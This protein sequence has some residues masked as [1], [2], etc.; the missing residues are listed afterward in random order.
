MLFT[1]LKQE[2][3]IKKDPKIIHKCWKKKKKGRET[4]SC[5]GYDRGTSNIL[6]SHQCEASEW[7]KL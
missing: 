5:T 4:I 3:R 1:Y 6:N 2:Q 7:D